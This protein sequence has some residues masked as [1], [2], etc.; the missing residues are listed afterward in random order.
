MGLYQGFREASLS[1][2]WAI[3]PD[4]TGLQALV[5]LHCQPPPTN[6]HKLA[7][8]GMPKDYIFTSEEPAP[9]F[10][11]L[12]REPDYPSPEEAGPA[13]TGFLWPAECVGRQPGGPEELRFTSVHL[14][15]AEGHQGVRTPPTTEGCSCGEGDG[16][17]SHPSSQDLPSTHLWHS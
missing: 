6:S 17:V 8:E 12:P 9:F 7:L 1:H 11:S 2:L 16:S 3:A 14:T 4:P 13:D 10:Y 5:S 15:T